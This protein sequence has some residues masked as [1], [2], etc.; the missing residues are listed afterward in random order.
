VGTPNV[1]TAIQKHASARLRHASARL[2]RAPSPGATYFDERV[3]IMYCQ[4]LRGLK[5]NTL[6]VGCEGTRTDAERMYY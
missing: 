4:D 5:K 3:G 1:L 6:A 2:R